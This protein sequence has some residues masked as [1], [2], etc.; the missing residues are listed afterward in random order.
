M[1]APVLGVGIWLVVVSYRDRHH[2]SE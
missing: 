2:R 1:L